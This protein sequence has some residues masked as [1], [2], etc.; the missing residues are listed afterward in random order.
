MDRIE[1]RAWLRL[2]GTPG[3][4]RRS[5]RKLL[6]ALGPPTDVLDAG[7]PAWQQ[8]V[9]AAQVA[10]LEQPPEHLESQV[11]QALR[12]LEAPGSPRA[13]IALGDRHYPATLLDNPD[14]PLMLFVQGQAQWLDQRAVAI[15]GSRNATERGL[16]L[17]KAWARQLSDAGWVVVSGLARGIDAQAHR[18][19]LQGPTGTIAVMGS[20]P[21]Q[22]YPSS[23]RS[24]AS[25]IAAHGL[26][27]SE[28]PPG[29]AALPSHFPQRNRII[30]GLC[31]GTV[32]IEAQLQSGSLISARLALESNREVM[33]VPGPIDS[34]NTKGCHALIKQ[35]A[36]LVESVDDI[37]LVLGDTP[38][39][40][41]R[42][43]GRPEPGSTATPVTSHPIDRS[44]LSPLE[45]AIGGDLLLIDE[46]ARRTGLNAAQLQIQL[47]ELELAGRVQRL[48]GSRYQLLKSP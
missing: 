29:V 23:H 17:A 9:G 40:V 36:A 11:D 44:D 10:A 19:A 34:P 22:I 14:P 26:L 48:P 30:T 41:A 13:I 8:H 46:L 18:G 12:W 2:L 20:G 38:E 21:D 35:G 4:G 31:R 28:Y 33:A 24:L 16:E 1:L 45:L 7:P 43:A 42:V 27:M 39:P 25:Q 32:V 6:S 37:R 3:L 5:A 47:L 15:V